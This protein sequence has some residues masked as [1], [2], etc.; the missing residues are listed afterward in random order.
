MGREDCVTRTQGD[1]THSGARVT[2]YQLP[3]PT[4]TKSEFQKCHTCESGYGCLSTARAV[5]GWIRDYG[6]HK[7]VTEGGNTRR[8]RQ[9]DRGLFTSFSA[10]PKSQSKR[11]LIFR[12]LLHV[13]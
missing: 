4:P 3:L 1:V 5:H 9:H 12:R 2:D 8:Y 11:R 10:W 7:G 13:S 6:N